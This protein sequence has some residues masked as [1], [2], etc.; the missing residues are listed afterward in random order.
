MI[1]PWMIVL[2]V[3]LYFLTLLFFGWIT[4]KKADSESYFTG[5]R[6]SIWWLVAIGMLSDS[7]SGVSFISV[8]GDV[9]N[10]RF[11]YMQ[12]V[13]GYVAG[14]AVIAFVL[15][16]LYYKNNL[17]SV[18]GYL[19]S[20][21]GK[22][23]EKI[24]AGYFILSRLLGSAGRLFLT[25]A[26]FQTFLFDAMGI[27]FWLSVSLIILLILSYTIKGG[28][29]TLVFTDAFQSLVL[30]GGL[31]TT[32]AL[33]LSQLPMTDLFQKVF[34]GPVDYWIDSNPMHKTYF[35]KHFLGGAAVCIA[36]TGLDQNMMQKNLSC[37]SLKEAKMNM[38]ST[39]VLV[40]IVNIFF[41]SM[42]AMLIEYMKVKG[43]PMPELNGKVHTDGFFPLIAF[44]YI[45]IAGGLAFILGLAAATFSSADSVLTTLTTSMYIDFLGADENKSISP[46]QKLKLKN[47]LHIAFAFLLLVCILL[48]RQ[49]NNQ[50]LI[51][52]IF[53]IAGITY[54]PL[55]GL[56]AFGI[57]NKR[58]VSFNSALFVCLLSP[59]LTWFF[60]YGISVSGFEYKMGFEALLLNGL[61]TYLGLFTAS[62][63]YR[64]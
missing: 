63:F 52:T 13:L 55:L 1:Q 12:L 16:P 64:K 15:L 53:D 57:L 59:T 34:S 6:Q 44:K 21:F 20:R 9:F 38:L 32:I 43:I 4:G 31:F 5:N 8:P 22:G 14:Y 45:G 33:L 40:F 27:P 17:T 25:A 54:G 49:L 10:T 30:L 41:V 35:W 36:M 26:V 19:K 3:G 50:A 7:M 37:R 51:T 24:G 46:E 61:L 11:Y 28:I 48:F 2:T 29:R 56:F 62:L 39:A 18:Y 42:G 60:K 58:S 23:F 47:R